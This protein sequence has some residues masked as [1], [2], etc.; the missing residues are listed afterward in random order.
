MLRKVPWA[1][2]L[3]GL[4]A[5]FLACGRSSS[6]MPG[7]EAASPVALEAAL[8]NRFVKAGAS[9]TMVARIG[10]SAK[11]R[12]A[13]ARPPV[14]LAL[15]VDTSGSM[16]GK[17]I[18]DARA[19]SLALIGSLAPEDRISVVVF[20]SKAELLLPST[21]L[22]DADAR[23]LRAKIAAMK[24]TGTTDMASGLRMAV[25]EVAQHLDREGVNR[26]VLVGDGVPNDDRQILGIV[27]DASARGISITALGLGNDY[28][29][30]LM[31]RVAQ[32]SG[33]RFFYVED[34]AKVASFFAEEVTRLHKVVAR[35]AVLELQPGPG[36]TIAHVVGRPVSP[37]GRGV[38]VNLG[39]MSLDDSQEVVVEL[40]SAAA[41]DG[42]NVEV[43]D[44]V[45]RFQE[46]V[47]GK[48]REERVFVGAKA[49]QDAAS[50]TQGTEKSV[51]EAFARARDA[52]ATL[53]RIETM[54][55]GNRAPSPAPVTDATPRKMRLPEGVATP[56]ALA[57][58]SPEE[59]RRQHD[60][61][62]TNFQ[63][64]H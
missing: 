54:R 23:D 12:S 63:A 52:A 48:A 56:A 49:T 19:A 57:K 34:S 53:E 27:A 28:D 31:G 60:E 29:E 1:A 5:V 36:V 2:A 40:A 11:R 30:T 32:Q 58:P 3:L 41:K 64:H 24:A 62:M 4:A 50:L 16:E 38:A 39:D 17:A 51:E 6:K 18:A 22:D 59:I 7:S 10:L 26:V 14:N 46:G 37:A 44:A 9:Q 61:A 55:N 35:N 13:T 45:L 8:G 43:L 47:G 33:G 42:A 15:L 21:K 25:D 20:H